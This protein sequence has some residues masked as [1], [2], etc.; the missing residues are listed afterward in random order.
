LVYFWSSTLSSIYTSIVGRHNKQFS[1]KS[2]S[3]I[4][5][6]YMLCATKDSTGHTVKGAPSRNSH[7]CLT[8]KFAEQ[9]WPSFKISEFI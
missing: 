3:N 1:Q 6:A 9:L 4:F 2:N 5:H 7:K 8:R